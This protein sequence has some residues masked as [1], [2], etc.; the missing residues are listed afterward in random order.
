MEVNTI[1][2]FGNFVNEF[3]RELFQQSIGGPTGTQPEAIAAMVAME[4]TLD[5]VEEDADRDESPV[6]NIGDKVYVDDI[7]GWW[8]V[9]RPR[10]EKE[11]R[12]DSGR[13]RR[14]G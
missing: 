2:L 10:R 1:H 4:E 13:K 9:F 11:T 14:G 5:E 3:G 12:K 6:C 8:L 7:C